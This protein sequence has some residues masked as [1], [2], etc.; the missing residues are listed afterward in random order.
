MKKNI[1]LLILFF[2]L[3]TLHAQKVSD[4]L[5]V[6][7]TLASPFIIEKNDKLTGINI[8]LWERVASDLNLNY[9]LV[10][11]QFPDMLKALENGTIDISI[12][13]LTITSNRSKKMEFTHS[14]FASNSTIAV[15]KTSAINRF[16]SFLRSFF[17]ANF[18][19]GM[20]VILLIISIFGLLI[21]LFEKNRNPNHFRKGWK[22]LF[23]GMWWSVVTMTTVGY[24]D[25][26]PISR[27]G[28]IIA[29]IWMFSGLLFISGLTAS[30]ASSLT[31]NS[32]ANTNENFSKYKD[33]PVGSVKNSSSTDF[34]KDNFFKKVELYSSATLGLK[35]LSAKKID[36]FLYDEPILKY[37]ISQS[38]LFND[39]KLL[40]VKFDLQLY[41]FG[42]PK[43]QAPLEQLISQKILEITESHEWQVVLNEY[44]LNQ[45]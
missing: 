1:F 40:P 6:G 18:L 24:G 17:N 14:F 8:W 34:L 7:H 9:K 12:N 21:W 22:G 16:F 11:M 5:I 4:T 23:D 30:V 15:R 44:G 31:V 25:K 2:I 43:Y 26:Y 3:Q 35:D 28:K 45:I 36:A 42:L 29:L 37:R 19:K 20:L 32:L 33:Q 39:L 41:A 13:P 27:G 10:Q 38:E